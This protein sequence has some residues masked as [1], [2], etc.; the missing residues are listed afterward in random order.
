M[1]SEIPAQL[2]DE[3]AKPARMMA[4][5]IARLTRLTGAARL[6]FLYKGSDVWVNE[7]NSIPGALA[8]RL[9]SESGVSH[10]QL[11]SDMIAEATASREYPRDVDLADRDAA[12]RKRLT[13]QSASQIAEKLA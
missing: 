6:D 8:F 2:Q 13:L 7:L 4:E 3:V 11:L 12:D 1:G 9:W 5:E 10:Y